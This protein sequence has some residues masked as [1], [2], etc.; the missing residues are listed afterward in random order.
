MAAVLLCSC[1]KEEKIYTEEELQVIVEWVCCGWSEVKNETNGTVT[2]ITTYPHASSS[3]KKE[4]T[5]VIAPGDHVKLDIGA[6]V[7]G[8][9]IEESRTATIKLA[10]GTEILCQRYGDDAWS[11]LFYE[12]FEDRE[13]YEVVELSTGHK[14]R[15]DLRVR[16]YHI[17]QNLIGVWKT[18]Q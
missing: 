13:E 9:S 11:K 5:S 1:K 15:H 17:N 6:Y 16:T 10:D 4:I 3:D 8:V 12:T 14:V 2:L 7:S 18:A